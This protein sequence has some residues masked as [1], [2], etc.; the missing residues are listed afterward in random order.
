MKEM[1]KRLPYPLKMISASID[2]GSPKD[3]QNG[4]AQFL[5]FKTSVSP[6]LT[7]LG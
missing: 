1:A 5:T 4:N 7:V 2:P 3:D 6:S